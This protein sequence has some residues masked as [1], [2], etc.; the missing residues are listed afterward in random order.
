M[1]V[2]SRTSAERGCLMDEAMSERQYEMKN[3]SRAA[4]ER[5]KISVAISVAPP[6]A[7]PAPS[8]HRGPIA[9]M[10]RPTPKA[11]GSRAR[12]RR[13]KK[14]RD[15]GAYSQERGLGRTSGNIPP[16]RELM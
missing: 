6:R 11:A 2:T 16:E 9:R 5:K 8:V 12:A 15:G 3:C 14:L 10:H 4:A 13:T 1:P 7:E